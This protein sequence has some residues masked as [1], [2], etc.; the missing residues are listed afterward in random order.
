MATP[1]SREGKGTATRMWTSSLR[2]MILLAAA[3]SLAILALG[4]SPPTGYASGKPNDSDRILV[5]LRAGTPPAAAA[6]LHRQ[7]GTRLVGSVPRLGVDV[8]SASAADLPSRL[9]AYLRDPRVEYAE[10]DYRAEAYVISAQTAVTPNDPSFSQQ[11]GMTK[12]EAPGAWGVT[13]GT[14]G[15]KI[16]ILDTG[17]DQDHEDLASK[18]VDNQNFT[19]S[20]SFDDLYGH[21]T[22]VA[23]IAAAITNNAT[24][25]AGMG[26]SSSLM[27]VKVLDDSGSG[28][29]SWIANGIIWAADHG[30]KVI[31]MSLGGRSASKT[32]ENAVN[33]A[34][35]KGVVLVAAAGNN[36]SSAR[37]YP[38]YYQNCI[39]VAATDSNDK[40][41]SWSN[42][43]SW[44]DVAAPGVNIFSTLTNHPSVL[45]SSAGYGYLSGTSMAT[46]HV[47]GLAALVW[48]TPYGTSNS[49][50]RARI[51]KNAD[52]ISG[53]GSYWA[54]GRINAYRAVAP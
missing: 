34:W 22:H 23:G 10:P 18:I 48:A 16:A 11:W 9:S 52:K 50:V 24:G 36:G 53:T 49:S 38:A 20:S 8:V 14:S 30:A 13:T 1:A 31:N 28:Y 17:I 39:A 25:V 26:W 35:S 7:I 33:Y 42:Y 51:E 47:A 37:S 3:V 41:A 32:L 19:G 46:P 4:A 29:Y 40:K 27:N 2:R 44:V 43:G 12:V 21:G 54:Y 6:D 5:K 15:V 45:S